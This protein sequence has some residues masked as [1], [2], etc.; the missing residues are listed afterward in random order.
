MATVD[1]DRGGRN[2]AQFHLQRW[3]RIDLDVRGT[4]IKIEIS[5]DTVHF[6]TKSKT[7][8]ESV[9]GQQAF[10]AR[11]FSFSVLLQFL[12]TFTFYEVFD[13]DPH[14]NGKL[15]QVKITTMFSVTIYTTLPLKMISW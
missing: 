13:F 6:E 8:F 3:G 5:Q 1:V 14:G 15:Q 11:I 2:G 7:V 4:C 12:F 10:L 9:K